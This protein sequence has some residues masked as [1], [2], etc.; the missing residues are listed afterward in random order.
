MTVA[1]GLECLLEDEIAIGVEGNHDVLVPGACSDWK[2]ASVIHVQPAEG[3]HRDEDLIGW[4]ICGTWGG[5][6]QCWR[7]QG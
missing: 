4:D 5:G 2:A 6:R 7:C 1:F 3:V